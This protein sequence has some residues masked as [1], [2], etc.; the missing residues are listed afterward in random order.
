MSWYLPGVSAVNSTAGAATNP[1]TATI[2]AQ[3]GPST[4]AVSSGC[5]NQSSKNAMIQVAAYFY[6]GGSTTLEWWIEHCLSTGLGSTALRGNASQ[7]RTIVYTG[8]GL[9]SQFVQKFDLV[10]GDFIRL[11]VGAGVTASAAGKI[12]AEPI[13]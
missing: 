9:T 4:G 7:G 11:R 5:F 10:R 1:T 2:I 13:A 12:Q 3:V 6:L 8:T